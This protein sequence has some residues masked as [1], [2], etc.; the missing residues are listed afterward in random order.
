MAS[1]G[2]PGKMASV[3]PVHFDIKRFCANSGGVANSASGTITVVNSVLAGNTEVVSPG[4]DCSACGTQNTFNLISTAGT[5]ITAAQVMLGP[6]AYNSLNQAVETMLP[7]PG[8]P[9]I[10]TGAFF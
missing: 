8:S 9:A 10:E 5:P 6:L 4:N 2:I 1:H 7:F 3:W